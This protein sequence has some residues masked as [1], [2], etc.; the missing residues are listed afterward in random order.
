VTIWTSYDTLCIIVDI[1]VTIAL[2]RAMKGLKIMALPVSYMTETYNDNTLK[3]NGEPESAS[4]RLPIAEISAANLVAKLALVAAL[5]TAMD[6][7]VIGVDA[8]QEITLKTDVFS[9]NRAPSQLAQRENKW[10]LRYHDTTTFQ[11]YQ[12]SLPTADLTKLPDGSEF[13]DMAG[14]E[15]AALKAAFDAIVVSP[16]NGSN[17]VALDSAQ[18]VG[19]N[20]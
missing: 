12:A 17:A 16:G 9:R 3:K 11:K 2:A 10:L 4:I 7:I 14:T 6:D 19:R 20:S 1:Q 18:F 13:L 5:R 8:K 15:G